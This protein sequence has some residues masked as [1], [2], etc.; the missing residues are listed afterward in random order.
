MTDVFGDAAALVAAC[1]P[2]YKN[3]SGLMGWDAA[4]GE[5]LIVGQ[6]WTKRVSKSVTTEQTL[7]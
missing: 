3:P 6:Q 4:W 5:C 2:V 7:R 1:L